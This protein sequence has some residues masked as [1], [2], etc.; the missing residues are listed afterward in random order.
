[1][2]NFILKKNM[3]VNVAVSFRQWGRMKWAFSPPNPWLMRKLCAL[4]C[5]R[6]RKRLFHF[7]LFIK[8]ECQLL[9]FCWKAKAVHLY[10]VPNSNGW[11][12]SSFTCAL[13][14]PTT[15]HI[16]QGTPTSQSSKVTFFITVGKS[17]TF[18]PL[19]YHGSKKLPDA[20]QRGKKRD[21]PHRQALDEPI[22]VTDVGRLTKHK[23]YEFVVG[24]T[25][26]MHPSKIGLPKR[27]SS[28]RHQKQKKTKVY[29]LT[30]RQPS[31]IHSKT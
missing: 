17:H 24:T 13:N 16:F 15:G 10:T 8:F 2:M 31:W 19:I 30:I 18:V 3:V 20:P 25:V 9:S 12:F 27:P 21:K 1:M 23:Q 28:S 26:R 29:K 6:K 22:S 7:S 5:R 11:P 4:E 14:R